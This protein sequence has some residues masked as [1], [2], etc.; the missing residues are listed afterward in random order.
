MKKSLFTGLII[1]AALLVLS[2]CNTAI[3]GELNED[4]IIVEKDKANELDVELNLGVGEITV[5]KGAKEWVEGNVKY[6]V[7]DLEPKVKYDLRRKKGDIVIEHKNLKKFRISEIKNE[8]DFKLTDKIPINLSVNTGASMANL[9]LQGLKIE[10]L[11]IET[12]VGDLTVDLRGD[13]KKS[14]ETNIETGV[15]QTTVILPSKVGVK[16]KAEKGIG[17]IN[18]VGFISK[19][20]DVYVNEAYEDAD[21]I[22]TVDAEV[23]VGEVTFKTDK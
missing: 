5:Q 20:N 3:T 1:G 4:S 18:V 16:I 7:K 19:G 11:D 9:D 10:N 21:V 22:L 14:F 6:N 15:G 12:G 2:G 13:W 17:T 23:G 8:W